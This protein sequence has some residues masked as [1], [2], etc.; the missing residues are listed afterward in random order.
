MKIYNFSAGPAMLP[1][2]VMQKAQAEFLDYKGTGMSLMEVSHRSDIFQDVIDRARASLIELME[3]PDDYEVLFVQGGASQ[4]FGMVPLNLFQK[5][6]AAYI[7]TGSWSTKAIAEA[8]KYGNVTVLA[9]SKDRNFNYI[10]DWEDNQIP[11]EADYLHIT[12]NNTIFGTR[13][14]RLPQ[15]SIPLV[16]DMSSNILSEVYDVSQFGLIYA[17]AQKNIGPSGV[18]IVIIR[19]ELIGHALDICPKMLDYHTHAAKG[20]LFNT[21]PTYAIYLSGLVFEWTLAQGGVKAMEGRNIAKA[22]LLYDYIDQSPHFQA[23]VAEPHRSRMNVCF[24]LPTGEQNQQFLTLA[25]QEGLRF[26]KGH[27]SVGGMRASLYNPV[28]IEGV[29]RLVEVMEMYERELV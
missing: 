12:T 17:G 27:R 2:A 10:P 24:Y 15:S 25:E 1:E 29:Q 22:Q 23:T 7:D 21:P 19:K 11:Q 28:S 16:A 18:T 5:R 14:S 6:K 4:Q 9:S 8:L 26:L 13:F 20:S 3:I